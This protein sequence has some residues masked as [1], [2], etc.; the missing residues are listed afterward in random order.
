MSSAPK[1]ALRLSSAM[2]AVDCMQLASVA[3]ESGFSTLWFA[4]IRTNGCVTGGCGMC[5]GDEPH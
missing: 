5:R 1:L 4:R 3:E 2:S